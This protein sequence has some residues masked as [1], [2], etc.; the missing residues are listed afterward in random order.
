VTEAGKESQ[1]LIFPN[2][3]NGDVLRRMQ[4]NG[5]D[6]RHPREIEFT[7][8]F[9]IGISAEQFA[10]HFRALGYRVSVEFA[11]TVEEYPWDVVV[12]NQMRPSHA[13]IGSF[14]DL[15]QSI[16]G[17]LGGRNDGWGCLSEPSPST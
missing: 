4:A 16:A 15:L 8:V 11:E 13:E 1:A 2:D 17:P 14:E 7:V 10:E 6:L 3:E 12:A 9:S 5:D